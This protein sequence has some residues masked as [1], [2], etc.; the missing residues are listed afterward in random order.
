MRR[1]DLHQALAEKKSRKLIVAMVLMQLATIAL[2]SVVGGLFLT[3]FLYF[4]V[5]ETNFL[6]VPLIVGSTLV[7]AL[8]VLVTICTGG[9]LK[10]CELDG[11][12]RKVAEGLRGEL[13][14]EEHPQLSPKKR[15]LLNVVEELA[16]SSSIPAPPV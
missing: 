9:I 5:R 4:N 11:G 16:I 13:I 10:M 2:C 14:D 12:G 3:L 7:S 1:F 6:S 15:R 8:A